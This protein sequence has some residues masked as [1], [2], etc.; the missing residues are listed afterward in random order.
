MSDIKDN[1]NRIRQ[2]IF[3]S[4]L[5][6]GRRPEEVKLVAVSKNFP[7]EAVREAFS[8]GQLI[9]GENRVQELVGKKAVLPGD[10]KWHLIGTL[11]RNKVK[12][13]IA[14]VDLIH[15]VD[16]VRLAGEISKQ[17]LKA[18]LVVN[19]LLQVNVSGE[20]TKQGFSPDELLEYI[21]EISELRGIKIKGLMTMAPQTADSEE[22]R[23]VFSGLKRLAQ[24]IA[25]LNIEGVEMLELSMGMSDDF[26]IAVE[27]GATLVR[28][29]SRIFGQRKYWGES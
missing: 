6:S 23:P 24:A 21:Q 29:G 18:G 12:D 14:R 13:I 16:S 9:F 2:E 20:L 3:Q 25:A 28:I 11:Q 1:L 7:E 26:K 27:E 5:K 22:V 10:I 19:I 8:L 15:S 4:C 17:A